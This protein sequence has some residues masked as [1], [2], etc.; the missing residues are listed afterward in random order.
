MET[1]TFEIES[2]GRIRR[3]GDI[4]Q[5][6]GLSKETIDLITSLYKNG[7][8][9][10]EITEWLDHHAAAAEIVARIM[11]PHNER[12]LMKRMGSSRRPTPIQYVAEKT[13]GVGSRFPLRFMDLSKPGGVP[14]TN[15]KAQ[16]PGRSRRHRRVP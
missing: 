9:V 3:R 4:R 7:A 1:Y 15:R 11:K 10:A 6:R 8:T 16:T 2:K 5:W 13:W 14:P 12:E